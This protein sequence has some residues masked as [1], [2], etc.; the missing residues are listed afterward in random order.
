MTDS[1]ESESNP[2]PTPASDRTTATDA[3]WDPCTLGPD[4]W[5]RIGVDPSTLS[6][7]IA[8]FDRVDGFKRCGGVDAL[9]TYAIDVWSQLHT[10]DDFRRKETGTEFIPITIADRDGFRY[11]PRSD[12][13]GDQCNLI[14]PAVRGSYS[15]DVLRLDPRART[16]PAERVVEVA[17]IVVPMLP[18]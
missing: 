4:V 5:R 12:H 13:S 9:R 3:L 16:S 8:G 2:S 15:V 10:I 14:F 1:L 6:P 18:D 7:R 17:E 11:R